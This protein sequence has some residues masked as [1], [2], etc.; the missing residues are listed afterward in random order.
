M[1]A[2]GGGEGPLTLRD[3]C[4]AGREKEKGARDSRVKP[5]QVGGEHRQHEGVDNRNPS[6][7]GLSRLARGRQDKRT[8][9]AVRDGASR[10]VT[11]EDWR[12]TPAVVGAI[13]MDPSYTGR[14]NGDNLASPGEGA[15]R[16]QDHQ[17]YH[18]LPPHVG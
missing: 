13:A 12:V 11:V 3:D 7:L 2:D 14:G 17:G 9:N 15:E 1:R 4:L 8:T 10:V 18:P 6:G 16:Q 5:A